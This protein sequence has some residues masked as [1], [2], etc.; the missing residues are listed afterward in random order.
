MYH[1]M[2]ING[3]K[4][5]MEYQDYTFFDDHFGKPIS[6]YVTRPVIRDY[7]DGMGTSLKRIFECR[8]THI[9]KVY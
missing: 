2:W 6:A 3:P 8:H 4:E 5:Q 7:L 1:D 9:Y